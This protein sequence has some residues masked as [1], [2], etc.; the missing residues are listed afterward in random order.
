MYAFI[1]IG[2]VYVILASFVLGLVTLLPIIT[3][4]NVI[5]GT[6]R[7]PSDKIIWVVAILFLNV[8]GVLMYYFV[9]R[10]QRIA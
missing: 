10:S 9:G 8:I 2:G 5:R 6:F 1:G 7:N 3:L 4:I